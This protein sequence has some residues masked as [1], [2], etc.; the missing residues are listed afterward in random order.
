MRA[1]ILRAIL[2]AFLVAL[3]NFWTAQG[4]GTVV[5]QKRDPVTITRMYTGADG[6]THFQETNLPI[7]EPMMKVAGV[8]FN[9]AA[10]PEQAGTD[11]T[12]AFHNAPHRRYVVTLRGKAEIEASG[13]GKFVA[14]SAHILLAEDVTGKGHRYT[15]R[16]LGNE[17]WIHVF[18]E[19]DQPKP[20]AASR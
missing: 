5:A 16:P 12:F 17:D 11:G 15:K 2:L 19:V 9:R 20:P 4:S 3:A 14:D 6:L 10:G 7:G 8:Q 13:G 18:I 1:V